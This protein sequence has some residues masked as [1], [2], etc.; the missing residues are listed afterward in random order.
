MIDADFDLVT[1]LP[2]VIHAFISNTNG[3]PLI[4]FL[5]NDTMLKIIPHP[6]TNYDLCLERHNEPTGQWQG[7]ISVDV[8][9]AIQEKVPGETGVAKIFSN[10]HVKNQSAIL[11]EVAKKLSTPQSEK[12]LGER[13]LEGHKNVQNIDAI[14]EEPRYLTEIKHYFI[15]TNRLIQAGSF[16]DEY[17]II[18][19]ETCRDYLRNILNVAD[20][21]GF[22]NGIIKS[23]LFSVLFFYYKIQK[24]LPSFR[25]GDLHNENIMI[26]PLGQIL[27]L[28]YDKYIF[29]TA[30]WY[31]PHFGFETRMIDFGLSTIPE[32][33]IKSVKDNMV[34]D[35]YMSDEDET[36]Y[37]LR[38]VTFG[39]QELI[40]GPHQEHLKTGLGLDDRLFSDFLIRDNDP[41]EGFIRKIYEA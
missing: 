29:G 33:G 10:V 24:Y 11:A 8:S 40:L 12:K 38:G 32:L 9:T 41:R 23:G 18:H 27:E 4:I 6:K 7:Q 22:S 36:K 16:Y 13:M 39:D 35:V 34:R 31:V 1:L 3:E 19:M 25:H 20:S 2:N 14:E 17:M 28:K 30:T 15:N 21:I 37:L 5:K 26:V